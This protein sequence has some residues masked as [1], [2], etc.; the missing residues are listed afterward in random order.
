LWYDCMAIGYDAKAKLFEIQWANDNVKRTK[1][2]RRLNMLF[3]FD[4]LE[5]F[6]KRRALAVERRKRFM[7]I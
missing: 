7:A 3:D 2:V 4:E 5:E 6:E 1:K